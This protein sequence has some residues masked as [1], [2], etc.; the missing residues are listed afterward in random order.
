MK[1]QEKDYYALLGIPPNAT[2]ADIKRAYR[3]LAKKYH[4]DVNKNSDAA[5]RFR[6]ITEA[7]DTLTDPDRRRRYDRTRGTHTGNNTTG[8]GNAWRQHTNS[9]N[10]TK[11]GTGSAGEDSQAASRIL[12][13]L[14]FI[15][16]EIRRRHP[17]IPRVVIII[18]SGT[19]GKHTRFGHHAPG[20]WNVAGEQRAEIMIS[21]EGLR[22]G[23][24]AVLATMLHEAAH[25]LAAERGIQDTSRQGRYHNR[26]FKTHA[27]ELGITVEHDPRTGWSITT[28][29]GHTAAQYPSHIALLETAITLWRHDEHH[30]TNGTNGTNGTTRRN[31][32]LIAAAC[33][34]GRSIRVAAS[35]LAAAPITCQACDGSFEPKAS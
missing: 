24:H 18:A 12:Q 32:N 20:R 17:E 3:K 16:L 2:S 19:E 22:R 9:R 5:E 27:E 34:C 14:E 7:Y 8:A 11:T 4:P 30:T 6:E 21:G 23:A 13:V 28:L 15:W 33:P 31:S 35:T 26:K 10:G 25:A 1:T 29:P